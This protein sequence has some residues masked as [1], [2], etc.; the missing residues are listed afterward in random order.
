MATAIQHTSSLKRQSRILAS[1]FP[2][3]TVTS[4]QPTPVATPVSSFT[5]PNQPF[6]GPQTPTSSNVWSQTSADQQI[7]WNRAW[8]VATQF[9]QLPDEQIGPSLGIDFSQTKAKQLWM[10][11]CPLGVFEDLKVLRSPASSDG[12]DGLDTESILE[13]YKDEVRRHFISFVR[14]GLLL[15]GSE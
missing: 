12:L 3:S 13:W 2:S 4:I 1:V 10:P 11:E 6:G 8:H 14:P 5:A 9:L 7:E 15:V